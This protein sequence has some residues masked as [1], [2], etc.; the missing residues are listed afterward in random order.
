[1]TNLKNATWQGYRRADGRFGSRNHVI[2]L[3][4]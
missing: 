1:M 4:V 2:V 3:P